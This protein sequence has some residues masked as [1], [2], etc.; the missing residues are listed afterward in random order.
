MNLLY[1]VAAWVPRRETITVGALGPITF[2]RGWYAYVGSARRGRDAR[3]ARHM[4]PDKPLRWHADYLFSRHTAT[5]SWLIDTELTECELAALLRE[6]VRGVEDQKRPATRASGGSGSAPAFAE[7]E[8]APFG[9]SDCG[10]AGHLVVV[11][12]AADLSRMVQVLAH[13]RVNTARPHRQA[14]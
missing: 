12:T 11:A 7:P 6:A 14:V 3:V 2:A 10:C 4:R 5:R 1:V 13:P 8:N 9:A